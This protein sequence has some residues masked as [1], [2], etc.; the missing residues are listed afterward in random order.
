MCWW[1]LG[2]ASRKK[3]GLKGGH[4]KKMKERRGFGRKNYIKNRIRDVNKLKKNCALL[5]I[6]NMLKQFQG[7]KKTSQQLFHFD[8]ERTIEL[9]K[10]EKTDLHGLPT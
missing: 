9:K 6:T 7:N 2:R 4:L 5:F 3:I 8:R 1:D 10:K